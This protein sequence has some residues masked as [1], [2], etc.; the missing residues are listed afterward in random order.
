MVGSSRKFGGLQRENAVVVRHISST[1]RMENNKQKGSTM[2]SN[3]IQQNWL[4]RIAILI[5]I[6]LIFSGYPAY[7]GGL[8]YISIEDIQGNKLDTI[9]LQYPSDSKTFYSVGYDNFQ[10]RIG[11]VYC[12]WVTTNTLC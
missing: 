2:Q 1:V 8:S 3:D 9:T 7:S 11:Y 12:N 10:N 6:S 5:G 4:T